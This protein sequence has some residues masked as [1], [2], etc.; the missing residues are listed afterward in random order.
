MRPP[1]VVEVT[2][3]GPGAANRPLLQS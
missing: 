1:E 2:V 3:S